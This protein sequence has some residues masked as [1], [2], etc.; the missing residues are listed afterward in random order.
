MRWLAKK[1]F[2]RVLLI[3]LLWPALVGLVVAGFTF[4]I[5]RR[6]PEGSAFGV[7]VD[8]PGMALLLL[9]PP[10]MLLAIWVVARR[11]Y[12]AAT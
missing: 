4:V 2:G 7:T 8:G 12:R 9:G 10:F 3:A 6:L 5:I 11:H 1:S